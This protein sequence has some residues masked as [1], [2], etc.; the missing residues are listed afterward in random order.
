M[1]DWVPDLRG[2]TGPKYLALAESLTNSIGTG[3][4]KPGARLPPQR[5][6]AQALGFD[7]TTVTR[8]YNVARQ[9]G[10][11][12]G[13]GKAGSF[14]RDTATHSIY[15]AA[16]V[17]TGLNT[18]PVPSDGILQKEMKRAFDLALGQNAGSLLQYQS[19][20][21]DQAIIR[22]GADLAARVGLKPAMDQV[23]MAAGGQ[24][25]LLA[26]SRAVLAPG[27][28]V[29]CGEFVYP[30]FRAIA[31]RLGLKLL[32]LQTMN[33]DALE[34]A[35]RHNDVSALYVVPTN[36]NPTAT[37]IPVS[38]R[39]RI[40]EV[41][42]RYKL[43][44]I[45]DDAYGL[46]PK[47]PLPAISS[48]V[49]Q[50]SW[51][52]L[53]M[54][55]IISPALRIAFVSAPTVADALRLAAEVH[56]TAVMPPPINAAMVAMWLREGTFDSLVSAVRTEAEWRS[57][58]AG[59]ILKDHSICHQPQGYHVW[60]RLP[61]GASVSMLSQQL[62]AAGVGAIPSDRFAVGKVAAQALRVSLG[63]TAPRT[64]V[65]AALRQLAG[66]LSL[67]DVERADIV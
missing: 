38:E 41:A 62:A 27:A 9:R 32:P 3:E 5:E 31:L 13:R 8:A 40:A 22:A 50:Q 30:G 67:L 44:I 4:L 14:V 23:V 66:H 35:C 36:D 55:K 49:P 19:A 54:S 15:A 46:L 21:G 43:Q 56:D 16:Q 6:L 29:A 59:R 26:V 34:S 52:I 17:D 33:A 28:K 57:D 1:T 37:T 64:T 20:G 25:A 18:P 7:L 58:L 42:Q 48:L 51:H 10:L 47:S 12:D 11:I 65:E 60:L 63:G 45:E 61:A 2:K 53:S 39:Q 24:N